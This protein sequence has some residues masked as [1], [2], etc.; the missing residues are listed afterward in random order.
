MAFQGVLDTTAA[1]CT[2]MIHTLGAIAPCFI[3]GT[4]NRSHHRLST[5]FPTL[6]SFIVWVEGFITSVGW[7]SHRIFTDLMEI[8]TSK[9]G[10]SMKLKCFPNYKRIWLPTSS[11][12]F[13]P[14]VWIQQCTSIVWAHCKVESTLGPIYWRENKASIKKS[15]AVLP[16]H[17]MKLVG[18]QPLST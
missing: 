3:L 16:S 1:H 4:R 2:C 18:G 7:F 12:H 5:C 17:A 13:P 15:I 14:M 6:M 10:L 11:T 8:V 9:V